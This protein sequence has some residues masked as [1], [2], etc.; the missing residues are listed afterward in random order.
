MHLIINP[1]SGNGRTEKRWS[2]EIQP[3]LDEAGLKYSFE[4]TE[5]QNHAT[6]LTRI[7]IK[8]G[9]KYIIAVGG[10]GT[11]SEVV[12]GFFEHNEL[13][14]QDCVLGLISSGTGSDS[15]RTLGH[16]RDFPSQI[17]ILKSGIVKKIDL[18]K[19]KYKDFDGNDTT[20][21]GFNV[22]DVGLGGDVVDRVNRTTKVF[23]GK[24]SFLIGSIRGILHHKPTRVRLIFDDNEENAYECNAN[25]VVIGNGKYFGGG[26]MACPHAINDDGLLDILTAE[27]LSRMQLLKNIGKLYSGEHLGVPGIRE[28]PRCKKVRIEA[29]TPIFL[30]IDG[31]QVGT[32]DCEFQILPKILNLKTI[33]SSNQ[34]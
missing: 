1:K 9:E 18:V 29:E 14:N 26:M 8:N 31:E 21:I 17:E 11:F 27:G 4:M 28:H 20:R 5:Y 32:T 24:F 12:N 3:L 34:S 19:A 10:D 33:N 15:I 22:L 30:D 7:A 23:G 25:L 6:E 16:E 2:K 13:I